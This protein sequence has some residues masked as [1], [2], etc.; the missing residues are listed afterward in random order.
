MYNYVLGFLG[1]IGV[2]FTGFSDAAVNRIVT[3][4]GSVTEWV[5]AL[6]AGDSLVGVDTTS[7]YP[8]RVTKLP[9]VGYQRQLSTEGIASLTPDILLGSNEMGPAIVLEQLKSLGIDVKILSNKADLPTVKA[10]L[11]ILGR[12]LDKELQANELF[13][14]YQAKLEL[15]SQQVLKAQQSQ[16]KPKVLIAVGF[17]GSLLISGKD[18]SANWLIE[19]AG[20]LNVVGFNGYKTISSETLIALNPD[21]IIVANTGRMTDKELVA[22]LVKV[23]PSLQLIK[24]VRENKVMMLDASLL[25]AG[26]GPR[27]PDA[28]DHLMRVFYRLPTQIASKTNT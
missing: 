7:L 12:L 24:A 16:P 27:I 23:N 2:V 28:V 18:T 11:S 15:L 1:L 19:Q 5:V 10:N 22:D 17:A 4:G 21:V 8:K 13:D 20:G 25:V 9:K 3:V 14:N 6:D 26:L